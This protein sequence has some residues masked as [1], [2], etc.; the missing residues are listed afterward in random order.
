MKF[1]AEDHGLE[2]QG[3][4]VAEEPMIQPKEDRRHANARARLED[5]LRLID[6]RAMI[7]GPLDDPVAVLEVPP[8]FEHV[9]ACD[10]FVVGAEPVVLRLEGAAW[11]QCTE[12]WKTRSSPRAKSIIQLHIIP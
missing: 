3:R 9:L 1:A 8:P 11:H 12:P 6:R 5:A 4:P 10:Q 2:D 7:A